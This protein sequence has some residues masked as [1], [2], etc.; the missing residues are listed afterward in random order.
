MGVVYRAEDTRLH[1]P[2][3]LKFLPESL[4]KDEQSLARFRREAEAASALNHPNICTIHDIGEEGGRVF[5][6]MEFLDGETLKHRIAGRPL[7]LDSLLSVSIDVA[8]ALDAAHAAGIVH[9]D[10]KPANIFIT[11]RGHSKILDFGLAKLASKPEGDLTLGAT[12]PAAVAAEHLTSPGTAVGTVAY[13]SPE[14]IRAREL[15]ARTDLFSFGVTLYEMATGALPFRGESSGVITEAILNRAPTQPVRLNPDLPAKLEEIIN[16]ALEKDRDLRFQSA[17]EI[18]A[19]LKRLRRDVDSDR[20]SS[21]GRIAAAGSTVLPAA[22]ESGASRAARPKLLLFSGIGAGAIL[23]AAAI[24]AV[25]HFAWRSGQPSAPAAIRQISHWNKPMQDAVLSPDGRTVA[26]SSPVAGEFQV[27]LMLSSGGDPLQLTKDDGDKSVCGF[28]R[29]GTEVYYRRSMGESEIWSVPTLGGAPRRLVSGTLAVAAPDGNS[30]YF[31][32]PQS[33]SVF[34]ADASG[35]GEKQV[36]EIPAPAIPHGLFPYPDGRRLLVL[37]TVPGSSGPVDRLFT[38]EL[39]SGAVSAAGDL[40]MASGH[41][42]GEAG[43]TLLFSR[44]VNGLTNIWQYSLASRELAQTTFGPGP[45]RSP[46]PDPLTGGIYYV[47]GKTSGALTIYNVRTK[48]FTDF[49]N[50]AATQPTL[51]AD[52][53]H[54]MYI[55]LPEP[56]R[57]ELWASDID[58]SHRTRLASDERLGTGWW[59]PDNSLLTFGVDQRGGGSRTYLVAPDGSGLRQLDVPAA[60]VASITWARDGKSVYASGLDRSTLKPQVWKV[61]VDGR[62]PEALPEYCGFVDEVSPDGKYLLTNE[63]NGD[64]L[65]IYEINLANYTCTLLLPGVPTFFV[66]FATDG[67]GFLYALGSHGQMTIYRQP[68]RDGKL[69]GPAQVALK[70]PFAFSLSYSGNAYDIAR[71]LSFLIFARPGGQADLFLQSRK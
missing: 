51:S 65:G 6:A 57:Q 31:L 54:V 38:V 36:G 62:K 1:R 5:L 50:E 24:F 59:S 58:G 7:D 48:Q 52:G 44:T 11:R 2:V 64:R 22:A 20:I 15:D 67:K 14:Q 71:D 41:V 42:W 10:I 56:G 32:R 17:A 34:R 47:N 66:S 4:A 35:L 46:M 68:W 55:T 63:S 30:V 61:P 37:A 9:R 26:F 25:V 23:L 19:D 45:D 70:V 28:S 18:R 8:D 39:G 60:H 13:M 29:D 69:T 33:R 43:K 21:S 49:V 12:A 16:K 40:P 3:A 27:Y 53:K